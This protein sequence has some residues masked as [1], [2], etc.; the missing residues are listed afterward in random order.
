VSFDIFLQRFENGTSVAVPREPVREVLRQ[1]SCNEPDESG[2]YA[3][4]FPDGVEAEFSAKGLESNEPF[5]G[6]AFHIRGFSEG[7]MRFIF[8]IALA[9]DMVIMPAMEDNPLILLSKDQE[10]HV[11]P[12][13][14]DRFRPVTVESP[15]ELGAILT[16]GF[17]GW[18]A[19]RDQIVR[20][21]REQ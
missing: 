7:L 1:T 4:T 16:G 18:S 3:V 9:G 8:E 14:L 6:C 11:P 19:Y 15:G 12:E 5:T 17:E 2:F 21:T 10:S 20:G 13:V